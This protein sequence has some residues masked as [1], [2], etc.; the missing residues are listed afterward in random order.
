MTIRTP[1][2]KIHGSITAVKGIILQEGLVHTTGY[3]IEKIVSMA[4]AL[5]ENA[6]RRSGHFHL[7]GK[8]DDKIAFLE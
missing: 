5:L 6:M 8:N 2:G 3:V 1:C 4:L 7:L